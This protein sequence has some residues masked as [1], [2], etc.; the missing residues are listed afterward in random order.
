[1]FHEQ[2]AVI[3]GMRQ[4]HHAGGKHISGAELPRSDNGVP[5]YDIRHQAA[6]LLVVS[7]VIAC[8]FS[9]RPGKLGSAHPHVL[10]IELLWV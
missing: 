3:D 4:G 7:D 1:M 9:V 6:H 8:Q 2:L 5:A 10:L